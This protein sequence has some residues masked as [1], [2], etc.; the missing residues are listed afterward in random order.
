MEFSA[1]LGIIPDDLHCFDCTAAE[2]PLR[3]ILNT[4]D[5]W[6]HPMTK[7][8]QLIPSTSSLTPDELDVGEFRKT[9]PFAIPDRITHFVR[10]SMLKSGDV[11][12]RTALA[13]SLEIL[14]EFG[15]CRDKSDAKV[16][17]DHAPQVPNLRSGKQL[18]RQVVRG[19]HMTLDD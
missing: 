10:S 14:D 4:S 9:A 5:D 19:Q 3:N 16:C 8:C 17:L 6:I 7:P 1:V 18:N 2:D 12:K 11:E 13:Q 15:S